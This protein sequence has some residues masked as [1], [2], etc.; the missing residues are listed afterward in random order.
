MIGDNGSTYQPMGGASSINQAP[1]V[2][3]GLSKGRLGFICT[4]GDI[5]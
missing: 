4:V 5:I 3:L 2:V 1:L